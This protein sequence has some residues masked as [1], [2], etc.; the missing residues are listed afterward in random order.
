MLKKVMLSATKTELSTQLTNS[1][2]LISQNL[3][4]ELK[5]ESANIREDF[6]YKL[7]ELQRVPGVI[8]QTKKAPFVRLQDWIYFQYNDTAKRLAD[9]EQLIADS[10]TLVRSEILE[11][12]DLTMARVN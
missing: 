4:D 12:E 7:T 6:N 3:L 5:R 8:E 11:S 9:M 10:I 2:D 1:T